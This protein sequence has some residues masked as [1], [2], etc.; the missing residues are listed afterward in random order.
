MKTDEIKL[1]DGS[2]IHSQGHGKIHFKLPHMIL[3]IKDTLYISNSAMN[4]LSMATFLKL[5]HIVKALDKECFELIDKNKIRIMTGSFKTL[6]LIID[7]QKYTS[8]SA[9][10]VSPKDLLQLHQAAGPPMD[11]ILQENV[12]R[13]K[14]SRIQIHYL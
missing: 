9:S 8:F 3:Q 7:T 11:R 4:L 5:K 13:S 10:T 2:T 14:H 6:N 1:A 12:P